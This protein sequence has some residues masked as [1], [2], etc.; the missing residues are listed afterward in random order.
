MPSGNLAGLAT[1][2]PFASR[3]G[4]A[5]QSSMF[6]YWYPAAA[7]PDDTIACA[8]C[9]TSA[10]LTLQPKAFQSF[11]PIGGVS[12]SALSSAAAGGAVANAT[13]AAPDTA[14]KSEVSRASG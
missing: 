2:L 4:S 11:H 1:R 9:S 13:A 5:Q 7:R 10:S 14:R 8:V 6:T 12:A 3:L